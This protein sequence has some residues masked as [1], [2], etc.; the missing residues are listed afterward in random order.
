M[1]AN[2]ITIDGS[3]LYRRVIQ[4]VCD[5]AHRPLTGLRVWTSV[6]PMVTT[7]SS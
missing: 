1:G 7:P 4:T 2:G 6:V 5:L 3:P